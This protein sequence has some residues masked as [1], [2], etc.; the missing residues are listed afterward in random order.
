MPMITATQI[1][2][3]IAQNTGNKVGGRAKSDIELVGW[4]YRMPRVFYFDSTNL[5]YNMRRRVT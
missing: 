2:I 3:H 4:R 1:Q 5:E